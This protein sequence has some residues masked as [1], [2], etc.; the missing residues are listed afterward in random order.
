MSPV[1]LGSVVSQ[2]RTIVITPSLFS[3]DENK[4]IVDNGEL[5]KYAVGLFESNGSGPRKRK[6]LTHLTPEEKIMRRFVLKVV[7]D[8]CQVFTIQICMF[9]ES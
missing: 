9:L 5:P 8:V 2:P 4:R 7:S 6:R 1:V 3:G